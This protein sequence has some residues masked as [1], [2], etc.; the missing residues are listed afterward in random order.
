M[1]LWALKVN[2]TAITNN[3]GWNESELQG[4][5]PL[6]V[7]GI[8]PSVDYEDVS[9]IENWKTYGP[10]LKDYKF[11]RRE[12][13]V[14]VVMIGWESLTLEEKRIASSM[15]AVAQAERNEVD[16]TQEQVAHGVDF[17][18]CSIESREARLNRG[19]SEILNRLEWA[20][21][22]DVVS[23]L[24][25][26]SLDTSYLHFGREGTLE[27]DPEGLFD[28]IEARVGTSFETTGLAAQAYVPTS[29]TLASLIV[30]L[31]S[32]LKDGIY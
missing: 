6:I 16:T 30:D 15:F 13:Q 17:H 10:L 26:Q 19:V 24:G 4:N 28:Y 31:M 8:Q 1:K 29:G 11:I 22:Q 5:E 12:I 23:S 3:A 7:A 32:I 18:E 20:D 14:L 9:T 27:G 25:T 21:A 2:G